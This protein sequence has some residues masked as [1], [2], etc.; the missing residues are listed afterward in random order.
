VI[1]DGQTGYRLKIMS[2]PKRIQKNYV[3]KNGDA[4][5]A[6]WSMW[7]IPVTE[8]ANDIYFAGNGY[9]DKDGLE[10][11]HKFHFSI[12]KDG[13]SHVRISSKERVHAFQLEDFENFKICSVFTPLEDL[14]TLSIPLSKQTN[15][16]V[17]NV[18]KFDAEDPCNW[19]ELM[20]I[21]LNDDQ[22]EKFEFC[23]FDLADKIDIWQKRKIYVLHRYIP[24]PKLLQ[25]K[26]L[27]R[28][29]TKMDK[30]ARIT[31]WAVNAENK[32][33]V[34]VY[35]LSAQRLNDTDFTGI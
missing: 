24:K 14:V 4:R 2:H 20:F 3:I 12:H 34:I 5:G 21:H 23:K 35:D 22:K 16:N 30:S 26:L 9:L 11:G 29:D 15:I 1:L 7:L 28:S 19:S 13:R 18:K 10:R 6:V 8:G 17:L 33:H 31:Y 27:K 32:R 25:A